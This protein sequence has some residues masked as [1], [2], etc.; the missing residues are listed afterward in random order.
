MTD[1]LITAFISSLAVT[2]VV[3]V[4]D[5]ITFSF[6]GKETLNK[7]LTLPLSFGAMFSQTHLSKSLIITVPAVTFAS[8]AIGKYINKPV[9]ISGL[10]R[11]R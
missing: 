4:F 2:Y 11:G 10:P 5:L 8:I 9:V 1:L 3:E 6:F 7:F